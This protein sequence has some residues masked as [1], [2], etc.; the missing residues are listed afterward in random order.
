MFTTTAL[1]LMAVLLVPGCAAAASERLA[2]WHE[3]AAHADTA[4]ANIVWLGSSTT[5]GAGATAPERRYVDLVTA[6]L[7][8]GPVTRVGATFPTRN[9]LPGVHGYNASAGGANSETYVN[10]TTRAFILWE[11][12]SLVVH[13]IGSNDSIDVEPYAVSAGDY[14]ANVAYQIDRLDDSVSQPMSH[15]LVHTY[16][17]DGVSVAKWRTYRQALENIAAARDNVAVLDISAEFEVSDHLGADPDDLVSDDGVHPSDA[18]HALM[19]ELVADFLAP[20]SGAAPEAPAAAEPTPAPVPSVE[21]EPTGAQ[22]AALVA[23][24]RVKAFRDGRKARVSWRAVDGAEQYIVRCGRTSITVARA[25]AVV[26]TGAA[27][28]KVRAVGPG[29]PSQWTRTRVRA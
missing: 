12:P 1:A 2:A 4:Q 21:Q 24:R 23:P 9:T 26:R 15:L 17:R 19:A 14:E 29:G 3:A 20:E 5:Y 27:Y 18:G 8:G 10:D 7:G 6:E 22:V 16:R 11:R 28:C 25:K 13:M